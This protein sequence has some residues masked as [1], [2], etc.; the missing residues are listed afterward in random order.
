M[1]GRDERGFLV[2][3]FDYGDRWPI[4]VLSHIAPIIYPCSKCGGLTWH[5]FGEQPAGVGV[6]LLFMRKPLTSTH[7]GYHLIC[8]NC[9]MIARQLSK[10]AIRKL[11]NRIVP[12]ELSDSIDAFLAIAPDAPKAYTRE[13]AQFY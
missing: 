4:T 2:G 9:T 8:N 3:D 12:A 13:F 10:Q 6:Q 5:V 7:Q 11:E 1:N